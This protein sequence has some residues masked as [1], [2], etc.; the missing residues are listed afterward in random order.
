MQRVPIAERPGWKNLAERLGFGFHS[1]YGAPYWDESHAYK[2]SLKQIEKDIEDPSVELWGMCLDLVSQVVSERSL[3]TRLAIPDVYH[4][5]IKASWER[6]DPSLYGRFDFH[7][8]GSSPAKMLEFNADTPT[9]L[10]ETGF[11]QW[12]WLEQQI[13][14][15]HLPAASDQFNSVQD[16]LIERLSDLFA[17]GYNLH[18][19]SVKDHEEERATVSYLMDCAK[20]AGINCHFVAI[21]DIGLDHKGQFVD[22][23]N[24]RIQTAFKLYPWEDMFR[25][26]FGPALAGAKQTWIEPP[27]KA[28]LSNKGILP[29]LWEMFPNHPNLLPSWFADDV[30]ERK[31]NDF[32]YVRKPLF[33]REGANI[34][35]HRPETPSFETPGDY[36]AEGYIL[37]AYHAPSKFGD[38]YTMIGSWIVGDEACGLCIREDKAEV[39]QDL[40]RFIPHFIE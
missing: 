15:G 37:Q 38:D 30:D 21:Q 26:E 17:P 8:D 24:F 5:W 22:Q 4:D 33:S 2:F 35:I 23:G 11:F 34:S 29:L 32:P 20:Q 25:E 39:T 1:M 27:W 6:H 19:A 3:L 36:G 14:A 9:A 7:Y 12:V 18:F 10:Y 28:I 16:V 40:S 13:E 31:M